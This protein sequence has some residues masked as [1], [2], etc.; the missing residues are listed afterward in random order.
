MQK[1]FSILAYA[2]LKRIFFVLK[3][4]DQHVFKTLQDFF[5]VLCRLVYMVGNKAKGLI[6]KR[7]FQKNKAR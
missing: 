6:L 7:M 5:K 4:K 2:N 3:T 1:L